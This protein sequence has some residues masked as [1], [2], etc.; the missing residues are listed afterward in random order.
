M[1]ET[2][3]SAFDNNGNFKDIVAELRGVANIETGVLYSRRLMLN[4]AAD[5]IERYRAAIAYIRDRIDTG[6]YRSD[7]QRGELDACDKIE[8]AMNGGGE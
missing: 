8:K 2:G 6:H 5:E 3:K 1:S 4:Q 7:Y